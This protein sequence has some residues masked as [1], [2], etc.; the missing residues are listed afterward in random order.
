MGFVQG[1]RASLRRWRDSATGRAALD[2]LLSR[3]VATDPLEARLDWL[4]AVV[5]WVGRPANLDAGFAA[6]ARAPQATRLRHLLN[7]LDRNPE[8][9]RSVARTLRATL[10]EA[11]ALELLCETGLAR[12][13]S[14]LGEAVERLFHR[15]LPTD[16]NRRDLARVLLAAFPDEPS[17]GWL[18]QLDEELLGRVEA[19]AGFELGPDEHDWNGIRR[20]MPDAL[21][22]LV[23]EVASVGLSSAFRRRIGAPH[24]RELP[25]YGLAAV[26]E[27]VARAA[28]ARDERA[29]ADATAE[30]GQRLASVRNAMAAVHAHLD[31]SGVSTRIVYQLERM[32]AQVRR[33]ELLL[34]RIT[35]AGG[36]SATAAAIARLSRDTIESSRIL[37]LVDRNSRL[38]AR[39]VVDRS[40]E[41][42]THYIAR[43]RQE[44]FAMFRSAAGGGLVTCVTA[45]LKLGISLLKA[46]PGVEGILASL[47][48][49][50]SFVVLQLAHFTLATKQPAMT[51]PALARRL[52]RAAEPGGI[53]A[54]VEEAFNLLRSQAASIFG[55]LATVVPSVVLVDLAARWA[56]GHPLLPAAK[57]EETLASLSLLGATPLYAAITGV[58]L[59]L[60]SLAAGWADNW[61]VLRDL[62]Q[63]LATSRRLGAA[64]GRAR[65][66]RVARWLRDNVSGLAGNVSLGFLLGM[67]PALGHAFG[68]PLDV[69]HVTL[70]AG[71]LAAA[72]A[73]VGLNALRSAPFWW[74]VGG[75]ASMA[76]LNVGVSF[77]LALATAVR[78]QGLRAPERSQLRTA[79]W[80]RLRRRPADLVVPENASAG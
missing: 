10:D 2:G 58:L 19:L 52:E 11:D 33:A 67:T 28:R 5:A 79:F 43:N 3:A 7:V 75:I 21:V 17:T 6:A 77:G 49:A 72:T 35:D 53:E 38:L 24:F 56:L 47:N 62:E 20:D 27:G 23:S 71:F 57:T 26:A 66:N 18:E 39:K 46:P 16:P 80:S 45:W 4:A 36:P 50:A 13:P 34:G 61:F 9:K 78:A 37:D 41:T 42:G 48:Y 70:S 25:F 15:L 44:Y 8:W 51:G 54:F 29:L 40:A 76:I 59:F 30:L 73:A 1:A 60:S 14:F 22:Y 69:R 68:L 63:G 74:A 32:S 64:F 31:Q 12:E 55:N 65:T